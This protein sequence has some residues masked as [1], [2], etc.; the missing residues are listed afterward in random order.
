MFLTYRPT[1][2]RTCYVSLDPPRGRHQDRKKWKWGRSWQAVRALR[3]GMQVW[4][5]VEES[6]KEERLGKERTLDWNPVLSL[7]RLWARIT[8]ESPLS[9]R[10]GPGLLSPL[11]SL[12]ESSLAGSMPSMWMKRWIS[13][14]SD[15]GWWSIRFL[16][17]SDLRGTF[18][19]L[20]YT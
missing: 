16:E 5:Q 17:V 19:W 14:Y 9:P 12:A 1:S 6:E 20:L 15:W 2:W 3:P 13:G 4:F 18:S 7:A 8:C 10:H 11:K